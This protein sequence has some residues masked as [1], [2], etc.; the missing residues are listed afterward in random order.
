[1]WLRGVV[2]QEE[3]NY[4]V[5]AA[6]RY[7]PW[8]AATAAQGY[9][10]APGGHRIGICG[11]A[12]SCGDDRTGSFQNIRSLSIRVARDYP[13]I[14]G[15]IPAAG[16]SVLILGAPGWGKT[17]LLRDLARNVANERIV[18]VVDERGEL[19][20]PGDI[21]QGGALADVM[22]GCGKAQG[23]DMVLRTMGPSSIAVDEITAQA[24]CMDL[25]QAA[26]CGVRLIATAHGFGL[27]DLRQR[28]LYQPLLI[29]K[30]YFSCL[31]AINIFRNERVVSNTKTI[32]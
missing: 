4:I 14:S 27:Q 30:D 15:K 32:V 19:F 13:G 6:S 5:N 2:R 12:V 25:I 20:P 28:Q 16:K 22:T 10:T 21:F 9:I 23:I 7:S 3:V 31:H 1:M 29:I 26:N 11:D 17:T 18:C 8:C 24:D